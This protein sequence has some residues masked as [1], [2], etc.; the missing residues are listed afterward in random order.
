MKFFL[1]LL[2]LLAICPLANAQETEVV[3]T[4]VELV[5]TAVTVLDKKGNFVDGLQRD[6]FALMVDGKPRPV[7]FFERIA[8]G[9]ARESELAAT[10]GNPAEAA[11]KPVAPSRVAGRTILFFLDD[12]HLSAD[13]MNRT[14]MM[15]QRF[16]EREMTSKDNVAITTASGQVGFLEQFTNNRAVLDEAMSRLSPRP[17]DAEGYSAGGTAKMTEYMAFQ[18]N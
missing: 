11:A 16:L 8:A 6:Q 3:R 7:A 15:L 18:L 2:L 13:S 14:R 9:S 17:Y 10:P 5:Q 4:N 12:L 1:I